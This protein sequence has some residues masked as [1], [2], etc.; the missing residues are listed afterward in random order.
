MNMK[1]SLFQVILTGVFGLGALIGLFVFATY[2][3]GVGEEEIGAVVVWGVLPEDSMQAA[4][5]AIGQTNTGMKSVS[6]VQ[7]DPAAL[8]SDLASAI[9]TG[10]SPD[11]VL[12][13]QEEVRSLAKFITPISLATLSIRV[14]TDTFVEGAG[15][16]AAQEGYY[17]IPF[18]VDPLVLF[19]NRSILSSEGIAKPPAT[20]EALTGLV[21]N[22][23]VL[24]PTRQIKRGLIALGTYNNVQNA[25][26][27]LSSL[28]LQ[29]GVPLSSYS[30]N[31]V[32]SGNLGTAAQGGVQAGEAVL[33]FYTQFADPSKISYTWNASLTN[34]RQMFLVGDLALYLGYA[35][36]ARYLRAANPNLN[37]NVA[38]LPQRATAQVKNTY[39]LI[40]A[41]MIPRG[42]KNPAGA[43]QVATLLSGSAEQSVATSFTGLAPANLNVLATAPADPVAAV[44]YAEALYTRGWMSP[45]PSDTDAVFS[46]MINN[47]ISGRLTLEAALAEA[48]RALSALLQQ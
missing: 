39:G 47:V 18:L 7:K 22:I 12:A 48:E 43:Y 20:W 4:L 32:L 40:Y 25:R 19:Y 31:G 3:S 36:E 11:L 17:G 26:G 10:A 42:A 14:F 34:S 8:Q 15:I 29:T 45:A 30:A 23:A 37:F 41:F 28:F 46:G 5:I 33:G 16:F 44:A 13:S 1:M 27:I 9:A 2:T 6:Y 24:T 35:S 21:P 38:L